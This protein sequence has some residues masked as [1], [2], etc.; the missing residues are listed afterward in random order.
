[1]IRGLTPGE[2]GLVRDVFAGELD[3]RRIRLVAAPWPVFR[4]FAAGRWFGRDWIVFP[5]HDHARDF[6]AATIGTQGVFVHELAHLWQA[7][8]G[9][10]LAAAKLRAGFSNRAYDYAARSDC[11][12]SELNIEQQAM[13]VQHRFLL[14]RG[15]A[16]PGDQ[17][18]YDRVCPVGRTT[19]PRKTAGG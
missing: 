1:M 12:W 5:R 9:V 18:F 10:L 4:A 15:V 2:T 16:V 11:V 14:S 17:A 8:R 6:A 19:R 7:G 13:V 3:P